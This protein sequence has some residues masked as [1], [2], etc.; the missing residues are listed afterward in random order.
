MIEPVSP[1]NLERLE[2]FLKGDK[3]ALLYCLDV[4][5]VAHCWDDLI[6][7]DKDVSAEDINQAFIKSLGTIPQN[8]FYLYCQAALLPMMCNALTMWLESNELRKGGADER[9]T[10]FTLMHVVVDIVHFCIV[11]KGG[12]EWA[13]E[14]GTEFWQLF[15]VT[16][17]ELKSCMEAENV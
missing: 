14:V 12:I 15:G 10:A 4:L 8:Q 9:A 2:Y 6:D 13:R 17:Q 1:H 5:Y 11:I 7:R 16:E 3:Q